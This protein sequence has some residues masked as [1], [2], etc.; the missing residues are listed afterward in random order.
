MLLH[1]KSAFVIKICIY[2]YSVRVEVM[3]RKLGYSAEIKEPKK[4]DYCALIEFQSKS[5]STKSAVMIE[6]ENYS[7]KAEIQ[8]SDVVLKTENDEAI[9]IHVNIGKSEIL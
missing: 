7:K 5:L 4:S 9:T 1:H 3:R 8:W 6:N 2:N